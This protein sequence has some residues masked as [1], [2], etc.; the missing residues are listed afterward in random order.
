MPLGKDS[1]G[2]LRLL[3]R[4]DQLRRAA[5]QSLARRLSVRAE[6]C[7]HQQLIHRVAQMGKADGTDGTDAVLRQGDR[8]IIRHR[9]LLFLMCLSRRPRGL[10]GLL[11][12]AERMRQQAHDQQLV[13][14]VGEGVMYLVIVRAAQKPPQR[15]LHPA[16]ALQPSRRIAVRVRGDGRVKLAPKMAEPTR[17]IFAPARMASAR[18]SL[19]PIERYLNSLWYIF[20]FMSTYKARISAK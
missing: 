17:T 1:L 20:S 3:R 8:K 5:V 6:P 2:E 13:H 14:R 11:I 16:A 4:A 18:S 12:E 7:A 15:G 10:G 9:Y 19:I